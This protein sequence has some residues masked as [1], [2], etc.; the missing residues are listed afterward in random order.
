VSAGIVAAGLAGA[1]AKAHTLWDALTLNDPVVLLW[2]PLLLITAVTFGALI[3]LIRRQKPRPSPQRA[4]AG[5]IS[6]AL[7][8]SAARR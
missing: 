6:G 4:G 1:V 7:V 5:E 2:G 8:I 3:L